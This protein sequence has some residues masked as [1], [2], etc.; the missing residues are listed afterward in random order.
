M[1]LI[2]TFAIQH[3]PEGAFVYVVTNNT[4]T[5]NGMTTNY[6][7]VTMRNI[8]PGT[9][10]GNVTSV[11]QGLEP[12]EVIALDNFNKLGE[13]IKVAP[14]QPAEQSSSR[15]RESIKA[16]RTKR[17]PTIQRTAR[18]S[19]PPLHFAARGHVAFHGGDFAGGHRGLSAT[20]GFGP[21]GSGF[22]HHPGGDILSRGQ[23]GR[24]GFRHHRS[25]G[26]AIRPGARAEPDDLDQFGRQFD[27]H[28][29]VCALSQYRRRRTGGAGGHQRRANL[30]AVRPASAS[31]LQQIQS[32]GCPRF[33]AG[34]DLKV[35][36]SIPR[37]KIWPTRGWPRK[38]PSFPAS[39]WSAS[40]AARNR[41]C[42][43]RPIPPRC[44]PTN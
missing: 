38:S 34:P 37:W 19:L 27:H 6:Q 42:A 10:D 5:T 40:W 33:D 31:H 28:D 9:A 44:R 25:A 4:V 39:V 20:A 14:R 12:G 36:A 35:P 3:N 8:T 18:E 22:S 1:S 32:G 23:P 41:P 17:S 2:P 43:S 7:T 21:A 13:G 16:V 11:P 29:A 30:S 15:R 24:G 26:K